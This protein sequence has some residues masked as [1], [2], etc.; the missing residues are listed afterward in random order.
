MGRIGGVP[1]EEKTRVAAAAIDGQYFVGDTT[2][3]LHLPSSLPT[4]PY[5]SIVV[6]DTETRLILQNSEPKAA[7]LS[8]FPDRWI[9]PHDSC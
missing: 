1:F 6:C 2:Y 5:W 9:S 7:R 8:T 4:K 3:K